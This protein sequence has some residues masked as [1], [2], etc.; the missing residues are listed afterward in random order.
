MRSDRGA[1]CGW[2]LFALGACSSCAVPAPKPDRT[3]HWPAWRG[4][5]RDGISR[6][7]GLLQ[8]WPKLLWKTTGLGTGYSGPAIVGS[9]L[10]TMGNKGDKET[11][12]RLDVSRKGESV[13]ETPIGPV[14]YAGHAPGTRSTPTVDGERVY[15]LGATG[16]LACLEVTTGKV[17]WQRSY[18]DDFGGVV[19][20]WGFAESVLVDGDLVLCTPGGPKGSIAALDKKTGATVWA[21]MLGD[22]ASYSSIIKVSTGGVDQY[23]AFTF[24]GVVGVRADGG[25]LLWRYKEPAH[26]AEWGNV[27]VMTPIW[28]EG[29]VFASANYNVGGGMARITKTATGFK[30]EQV[31]FTEE[32]ANHHG[33][34]VLVDGFLYGCS[35]P[36]NL[37]CLE[38]ETGKVRW[39]TQEAGKCSVI[40]ADG[41]LYCR[42]EKGP[43][44][45][46]RATPDGFELCGR[47]NQPDRSKEKAW[48]HLVVADGRLY[49]RDQDVL[50]CYDVRAGK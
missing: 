19:P 41:M 18:V 12:L 34:L 50:L 31:Y 47:F 44:S 30:A 7:K 48:P 5:G 9:E 6:E 8:S 27:N 22:K 16:A 17:L 32:M 49:V 29:S 33:G 45:L 13:W 25:E 39:E 4:A 15:V 1:L 36:R 42:D 21:S 3:E 43:I 23:V 40:Y 26:T 11:V 20:K 2:L 14:E 28:F 38:Y 10:Y 35:N 46:V 24:E 37:K